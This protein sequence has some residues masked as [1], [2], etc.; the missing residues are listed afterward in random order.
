MN[1]Y[2]I[3]QWVDFVRGLTPD[4]EAIGMRRHLA[5]GCSNCG[6]L[7]R[8]C[9]DLNQICSG[10][11]RPIPAWLTRKVK[12][13]VAPVTPPR[14]RLVLI[15]VELIYDSFLEPAPAGLRATWQ[16]GWQG[17]YRAGN[18]SLDLRVEPELS[19]SR[20]AV[21]GQ[22][23]NY[24]LPAESMQD[25]PVV[26]R[27]GKLIVAETRSNRFGEFQM[28]YRQD[29][30]LQLCVY[31]EDGTQCIQVPLKRISSERDAVN[32]RLGL[33]TGQAGAGVE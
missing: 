19:T 9:D 33:S 12:S 24:V 4:A 3:C 6:D 2:G 15:P 10:M 29:R 26:L 11:A 5:E 23:S 14:R 13:F 32:G 17:L 30:K 21:I 28:E 16:L 1:H 20:A 25:V 27:S 8:F 7:A 31:L 18:C 22:I